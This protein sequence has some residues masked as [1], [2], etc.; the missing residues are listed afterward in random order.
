M[1]LGI[2]S[3]LGILLFAAVQ[4]T[5]SAAFL[6][7]DE[8]VVF[9]PTF[10]WRDKDGW[11]VDVHGRVFERGRS[12]ILPYILGINEEGLTAS[13]RAIFL[14]RARLFF[15]DSERRKEVQVAFGDR[16]H[17]LSRSKP[18]GHFDGRIRIPE[19]TVSFLAGTNPSMTFALIH[20]NALTLSPPGEVHLLEPTGLSVISDIDDTIKISNVRDRLEL[21]RNTFCRPFSPAP[22][23]AGLYQSWV[24]KLGAQFHYVSASPWQLYQPLSQFIRSNG[25]PA[26]TF[27]MKYFRVKD[28]SFWDLFESPEDYKPGVIKPILKRFPDRQF[29]LVGDSGEK[30]PEIYGDIARQ[31]RKQV[32]KIYIRDVTNEP[33][34]PRYRDAFKELPRHLW[35]VFKDPSELI[36]LELE[37]Y[38]HN[39][40]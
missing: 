18:N 20:S 2:G 24:T 38:I 4:F 39:E 29:V 31:Y 25:F 32:V 12:V 30:D 40:G 3:A 19:S 23:M 7:R 1:R 8:Q 17:T 36:A 13:E 26:G 5:S 9:Y 22:G 15:E 14:S 34:A 27:H 35:T 33:E 28:E 10:G 6:S 37:C 11:Q 21:T 16:R